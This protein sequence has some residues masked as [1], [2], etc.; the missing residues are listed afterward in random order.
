MVVS[1]ISSRTSQ[2]FNF[3]SIVPST[4]ILLNWCNFGV[5]NC[6][7]CIE[8]E[9]HT[10]THTGVVL[11]HEV[12]WIYMDLCFKSPILKHAKILEYYLFNEIDIP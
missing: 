10:H 1:K 9:R 3:S 4:P 6:H 5:R 2:N 11:V 7:I 8:R 12:I